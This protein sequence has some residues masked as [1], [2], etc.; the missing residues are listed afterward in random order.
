MSPRRLE[1]AVYHSA[2]QSLEALIKQDSKYTPHPL[3]LPSSGC[4]ALHHALSDPALIDHELHMLGFGFAGSPLHP[5][6][7]ERRYAE[8]QQKAGKLIIHKNPTEL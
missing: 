8:I 6:P 3:W 7:A 1:A 5:W 4:V 2:R